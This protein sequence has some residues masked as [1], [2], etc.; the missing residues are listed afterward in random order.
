VKRILLTAGALL[1]WS[2]CAAAGQTVTMPVEDY[3]AILERLDTL[4]NRVE[5][6]ETQKS[7]PS[8]K[9]TSA[10]MPNK[11]A[12]DVETIYDTLDVVE[13]K[14]LKDRINL[15]AELR[16]RVDFYTAKN[17]AGFTE[18]EHNDG[19][20]SNRF[21]LNMD[22]E[23]KKNLLFTGRLAVYK[24]FADT[25]SNSFANDS[26]QVTSPGSSSV[27]LERAYVDWIPE[28]LPMPVAITMGRHPSTGGP[29]ADLKENGMRQ[30]TYPSLLFDGETDGMV[31]TIGL[32]RYLGWKSSGLRFAWG[33]AHQD[34]NDYVSYL[35]N[36]TGGMDDTNVFALF[37]ESEIPGVRNSV[38]VLSAL[39][40]DDMN[41]NTAYFY[42]TNTPDI[43]NLG[44]MD[45][46]GVVVQAN[47][48]MDSGFDIFLSTGLNRTHPSGEL[49]TVGAGAYGGVQAG[50]LN[51]DGTTSHTGWAVHT[52]FRYTIPYKPLNNPKL[53]FEY[54]HGSDYWFS[55][56]SGSSDL[57]NKL[58]TRGDAYDVYYIQPFNDNLFA[59]VGYTFI[60]YDY[61]MSGMHMGDFGDQ[62]EE[63]LSN[64]YF[65]LDCRF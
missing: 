64:Y 24:N 35:D 4:Q 41:G 20:W 13:T 60:D 44:D 43:A 5:Q 38:M 26:N 40:V 21:R 12:Q 2:S 7:S 50:L 22:A 45:L 11:L 34:D 49:V 62:T 30:S 47:N 63:E 28:G 8:G 52:G 27:K 16:T 37:F 36:S 58:A 42:D 61:N 23:I 15:G 32:E 1:A 6:L 48:F 19:Q 29:P 31:A 18:T 57:Y 59:R 56:T 39:R 17:K 53:G 25:D 14:T 10:S 33:K 55:F 3:K 46:Y 65:M 9:A 54:N 51:D